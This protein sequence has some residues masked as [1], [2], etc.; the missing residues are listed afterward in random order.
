MQSR[1]HA[2]EST[3]LAD[4]Q[5]TQSGEE[6]PQSQFYVLLLLCLF[7][8]IKR[9]KPTHP[10]SQNARLAPKSKIF[11]QPPIKQLDLSISIWQH[12][13]SVNKL[14]LTQISGGQESTLPLCPGA[15]NAMHQC[16]HLSLTKEAPQLGSARETISQ[17]P[18]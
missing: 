14:M 2:Q 8:L 6:P 5:R 17:V 10:P 16:L 9:K 12:V 13:F 4:T 15:P 1:F 3:D 18:S 7:P 11:Q